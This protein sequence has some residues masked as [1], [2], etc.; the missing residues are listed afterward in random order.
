M[1]PAQAEAWYISLDARR[2]GQCDTY[3]F[4]DFTLLGHFCQLFEALTTIEKF[5]QA[6]F[7]SP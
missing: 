1:P 6:A 7:T 2:I 3:H 4:G 5:R